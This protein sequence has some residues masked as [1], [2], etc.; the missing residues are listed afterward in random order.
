[1]MNALWMSVPAVLSVALLIA[2][3]R[4]DRAVRG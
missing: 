4:I 1:M 2:T 3:L